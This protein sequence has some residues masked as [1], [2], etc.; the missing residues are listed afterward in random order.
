MAPLAQAIGE[1][2]L[3]LAPGL[4]FSDVANTLWKLQAVAL[5]LA[6]HHKHP[7]YDGLDLA[8]ARREAAA[9]ISAD[10]RLQ[11]RAERVLP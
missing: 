10:R 9:L 6:S 11:Q 2:A 1:A 7:V 8:L 5:A 4:M 3:V